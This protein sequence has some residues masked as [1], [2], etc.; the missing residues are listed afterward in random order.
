MEFLNQEIVNKTA[1]LTINHPPANALA[2]AVISE[3]DHMLNEIETNDQ[4]RVIVL[5]GEGRFFSAG[6]DIKEFTSIDSEKNA[7]ELATKGQ[8]L[9]DR[10][11]N[12]P[13]PIIAA[14][15][16]AALG[17]GLE[18]AMSCHI[19][20]VSETAKLGLPELSLGIIPGFAGTQRLPKYVG[21]AK[22][23]EMML[24]AEPVSGVDAVKIGLANIAVPEEKLLDEA[25][26]LAKKIEMKSPSTIKVVLNLLTYA[27]TE[28][29]AKGVEAEAKAFG[30]VFQTEDATEGINAFLEKRQPNFT[31]K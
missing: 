12:F 14:I 19:R 31:G 24:T 21:T 25:M 18:L 17:G 15:H 6:A 16:G 5:K 4:V 27:K 3:L 11:E 13:K 20:I 28:Q 7:A 26:K 1:V 22:A 29:Y 9:M 8:K 10:I 23:A 2:G 30:E